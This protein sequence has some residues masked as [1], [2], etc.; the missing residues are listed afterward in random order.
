[1]MGEVAV[2]LLVEQLANPNADKKRVVLRPKLV[3]RESAAPVSIKI[4]ST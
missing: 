2:K 4:S 1:M 3:V